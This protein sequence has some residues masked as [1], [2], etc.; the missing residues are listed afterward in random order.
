[1][2][3]MLS[4][5]GSAA[6]DAEPSRAEDFLMGGEVPVGQIFG[7]HRAAVL[8]KAACTGDVHTIESEVRNGLDPDTKGAEGATPLMWSVLCENDQGIEAL[9][10][11]GANPNY[12]SP[13]L[14]G[15][16]H[17]GGNLPPSGGHSAVFL[18][19]AA[20]NP[21]VLASMLRHG[22][23]P[24]EVEIGSNRT[25][26]CRALEWGARHNQWDNYY[27][28]LNAG[29]NINLYYRYKTI[30]YCALDMGRFDKIVEL[31]GRGYAVRLEELTLFIKA[32]KLAPT[33]PQ[34]VWQRRALEMLESRGVH[35]KS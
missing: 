3:F 26:L 5:V 14:S 20:T 8:V 34:I 12:N 2:L 30:A 1:M 7:D 6:P 29:A 13:A 27:A 9:L 21:K 23:D 33:D 16:M 19:A 22:G 4:I 17:L 28:L 24:N 32:H 15:N 25:A 10:K 18:A 11:S 31:L 35:M